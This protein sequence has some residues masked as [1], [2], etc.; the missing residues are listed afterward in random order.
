MLYCLIIYRGESCS[1]IIRLFFIGYFYVKRISDI[2]NGCKAT[3]W[4]GRCFNLSCL[5][6][7][8]FY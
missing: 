2:P 6:G 4:G 5:T 3:D 7:T 1:H 8:N